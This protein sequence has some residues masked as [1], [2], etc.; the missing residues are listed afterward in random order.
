MLNDAQEERSPVTLGA[1]QRV[2]QAIC[3][4]LVQEGWE[5]YQEV[6]AGLGRVDIV[7][8]RDGIRWAIEVKT[9]LNL[10]VLD[11]AYRNRPWFHFSSVAVP[12]PAR[13]PHGTPRSWDI[14]H[15][16]AAK[17]GFGFIRVIPHGDRGDDLVKQD[18]RPVLNRRPA[19]VK[20]YEEQKT[21][22]AAGSARGG[23]FTRFKRTAQHL[24]RY[25]QEHPGVTLKDAL[26]SIEHHYASEA[27]A[28]GAL[29]RY[30]RDGSIAGVE[31]RNGRLFGAEK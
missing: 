15:V 1:E 3:R 7:A 20:L 26:G 24:T 6:K 16:M 25:V 14:A 13:H 23:Y 18:V 29:A 4:W 28:T 2:A 22:V 30:I 21:W 12:A 19:P 27:S 8:V 10:V 5:V 31:L 17:L 9:S 11:Q